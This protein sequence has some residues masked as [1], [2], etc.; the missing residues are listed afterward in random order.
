M[1]EFAGQDAMAASV[2]GQKS[3]LTAS[4]RAGEKLIRGRPERRL[5]RHPFLVGEAFDVVKS[6]A[7][8]D[9]DPIF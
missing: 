5:D 3:D 6:A 1:I 7:T 9:T 8:D 4:Q 2:T